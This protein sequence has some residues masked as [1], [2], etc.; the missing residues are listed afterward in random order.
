[1]AARLTSRAAADEILLS[2]PVH[3]ALADRLHAEP[4]PALE[5]KGFDDP[6]VAWRLLDLRA[7]RTSQPTPFVGRRLELA[8]CLRALESC[9]E[10][11]RGASIYLRGE[12]GIGK[13]R[14]VEEL[15]RRAGERGIACHTG[16]ALDFGAGAERDPVRTIA[17]GLVDADPRDDC[18]ERLF[19]D[20]LLG[21]APSPEQRALLD[22]MDHA[23]RHR[24]RISAFAALVGRASAARPLLLVVEDL[25]WAADTTLDYVARLCEISADSRVLLVMTSRVEND[26]LGPAWRSRTNGVGLVT[27]DLGP[28]R[29]EDAAA[30]AAAL[31]DA[32]SPL[33]RRC[34]ARANGNPLFLEQLLRHA[35]EPTDGEVPATVQSVVLARADK[36][37]PRDRRALQVAAVLGQRFALGAMRHVLAD[38]TYSPETLLEHWLLRSEGNDLVFNHA[39]IRDGVYGSLLEASLR[40][41]HR[42]AAA[43][44]HDRDLVVHAEHLER[45]RDRG[46]AGAYAKAARAEMAAYRPRTALALVAR[47]T[48]CAGSG[49]DA[50]ALALLEAEVR[51]DLTEVEASLAASTRALE[52]AATN[53]ERCAARL[54]LAAGLRLVDRFDEAF[55][56]L[57]AAEREALA[58][59]LV[60]PLAR[61]HHLRGNLYFPQGRIA[62][63][64]RE[65]EQALRWANEAATAELEARALSGLGDVEY[66]CGRYRSAHGRFA[67]CL[68]LCARHGLGKLEVANR[69]MLAITSWFSGGGALAQA[70]E[71]IEA[72]RRVGQARA[73]LIAHH[74]R[75]MSLTGLMRLD[76]ARTSV[77]RARALAQQLG[78]M[79]FEAENIWFLATIERL[80]GN[81]AEATT[82]LHEALALSRKTSVGFFGAAILG[83]LALATADAAERAAALCEG[84]ALLDAGS[85]SHNHFFFARD[86]IDAAL[87]VGDLDRALRYAGRLRAYTAAEPLPWSDTVIERAE[88]LVAA[89]RGE[90]NGAALL[91][92]K[93]K[94]QRSGQLDLLG[95]IDAALRTRPA[96]AGAVC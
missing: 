12:A 67:A 57:A 16:V 81:A 7:A 96:A 13:S 63:C 46:A 27:I 40:A 49:G 92:L 65:H 29:A 26:P 36:L 68:D 8:Q 91:E 75:L 43:W 71:A 60:E 53:A 74:G 70:D 47:G 89:A 80:A 38:A 79:R 50:Y 37:P 44:Y 48:A 78:A 31:T 2:G 93:A 52:L 9:C 51:L 69:G 18:P 41:Y 72:A 14:V 59:Q 23:T 17:R 90:A 33:A 66:I 15:R 5:V 32:D 82:R 95:S 25:H 39:L 55:G 83:S 24:G 86:G 3:E 1:L 22:A 34:I 54:G 87:A 84:E 10:S 4:L 35:A 28:L 85:V 45:A 58:E 88:A 77:A 21:R 73:E 19:V 6:V 20:D 76:E 64:R 61:V 56:A 11:G 62:D 42:A 30:L 94:A